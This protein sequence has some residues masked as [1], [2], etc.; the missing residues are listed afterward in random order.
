M[1]TNRLKPVSLKITL[2][3][4]PKYKLT[5]DLLFKSNTYLYIEVQLI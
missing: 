2:M 4:L 5:D 3:E 1:T